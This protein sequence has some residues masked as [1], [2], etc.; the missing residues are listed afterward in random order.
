MRLVETGRS[1]L[2]GAA[3]FTKKHSIGLGYT[4]S[5]ILIGAGAVGTAVGISN[6]S[7]YS[8]KVDKKLELK[9]PGLPS[10]EELDTISQGISNF[11]HKAIKKLDAELGKGNTIVDFSKIHGIQDYQ[12]NL[13]FTQQNQNL[14]AERKSLKQQMIDNERDKVIAELLFGGFVGIPAGVVVMLRTLILADDRKY[15]SSHKQPASSESV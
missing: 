2:K 1:G 8:E 6:V 7:S 10:Q 12:D 3:E 13:S 11:D 4:A 14:L 15:T 9:Y 5:A